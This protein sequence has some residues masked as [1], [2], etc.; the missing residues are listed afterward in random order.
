[1]IYATTPS[2]SDIPD[3]IRDMSA[4][5]GLPSGLS[6][7]GVEAVQFSAVIDGALKDHCHA[8]NPRIASAQDY[9]QLLSSSM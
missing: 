3:A 4:R 1:M 2:G 9:E 7:M 5:L 6:A 8:T